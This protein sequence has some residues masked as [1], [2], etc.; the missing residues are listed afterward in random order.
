LVVP[1]V[2]ELRFRDASGAYRVF[3]IAVRDDAVLVFHAFMKK[4]AATPL[5]EIETGRR[6]LRE[7]LD[8]HP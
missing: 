4:T 5:R 1:G 3:Y 7:L 8:E 6:R 2:S